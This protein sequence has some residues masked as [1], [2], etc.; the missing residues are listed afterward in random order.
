MRGERPLG[1]LKI[2]GPPG[3]TVRVNRKVVG[4]APQ[5][6]EVKR[7]ETTKVEVDLPGGGTFAKSI[8]LREE[9][10]DIMAQ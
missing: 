6:V 8:Y 7:F 1:T 3:A 10:A 5:T 2:D 4:P 9:S